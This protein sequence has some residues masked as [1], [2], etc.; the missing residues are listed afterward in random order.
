MFHGRNSRCLICLPANTY[1][2]EIHKFSCIQIHLRIQTH[3]A[4]VLVN[5]QLESVTTSRNTPSRKQPSRVVWTIIVDDHADF[6]SS[7][8]FICKYFIKI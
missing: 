5:C 1:R 7:T 8:A 6:C 2:N 4:M 3:I